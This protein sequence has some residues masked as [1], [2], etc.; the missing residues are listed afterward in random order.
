MRSLL[1]ITLAMLL[2][3]CGDA[4]QHAAEKALHQGAA[5]Y[6]DQRYTEA[7]AIYASATYDP[8]VAYNLGNALYRM[9]LPDSATKTFGMVPPSDADTALLVATRY[10]MANAWTT[11]A[12]EADSAIAKCQEQLE[13][14]LIEGEDIARKVRMAVTRDSLIH[15][16]QRLDHLVDSALI[17]GANAYKGSLRMA[18]A[19]EDARYNLAFVQRWI[20][21]RRKEAEQRRQDQE[22]N[23]EKTLTEKAL[24]LMKKADELV[25]LYKFTE[26]LQLLQEG[27][28]AEPSLQQ[29]QEYMNKL[30]VVTKAAKAQ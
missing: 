24:L 17:Q 19:D 15:A 21:Q 25:D 30:D 16:R 2:A 14:S 7:A 27:L 18:P 8:R 3:G 20:A 22:K 12:L 1:H 10:N 11:I 9:N 13:H 28:K 26:A 5:P 29:K 4:A 23:E 6:H